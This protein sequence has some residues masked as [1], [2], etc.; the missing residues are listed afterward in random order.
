MD[1]WR[2]YSNLG[3][4]ELKDSVLKSAWTESDSALTPVGRIG[5]H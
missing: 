5:E 4:R 1:I 2:L 3:D